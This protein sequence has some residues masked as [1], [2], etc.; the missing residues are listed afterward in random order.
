MNT[1]KRATS[2][3]FNNKMTI[4]QLLSCIL[5]MTPILSFAQSPFTEHATLRD[6]I[7][8]GLEQNV[9]MAQEKA[10]L[11]EAKALVDKM[12]AYKT[13]KVS[14]HGR[15]TLATGGRTMDLPLGD[16][17]NPVY[18]ELGFAQRLDNE[19]I[20]LLPTRDQ[21]T[22]VRIAQPLLNRRIW[23]TEEVHTSLGEQQEKRMNLTAVEIAAAI[24]KSYYGWIKALNAMQIAEQSITESQEHLRVARKLVSQGVATSDML[25]GAEAQLFQAEQQLVEY[26]Y[27][28][29]SVQSTLNQLLN[30][31]LDDSIS[32]VPIDTL[33]EKSSIVINSLLIE[34][35]SLLLL[36][37][38]GRRSAKLHTKLE[39]TAYLPTVN[40]FLDLGITGDRYSFDKKYRFAMGGVSLEWEIIHGAKKR[41]S[42]DASRAVEKRIAKEEEAVRIE[43][44]RKIN[45]AGNIIQTKE[46]ALVV[47]KK[48]LQA[49]KEQYRLVIK[50]FNS[51]LV[52]FAEL[53][54]AKSRH[55]EASLNITIVKTD[56]LSARAELIN[57][58]GITGI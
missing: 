14:L 40:A 32:Y 22:K 56:L 13:P 49:A 34:N 47:A 42:I 33:L 27:R 57:S 15:Y 25:Y 17:L 18:T 6:Y 55:I 50:K 35:H 26:T 1:Q 8:L 7:K 24:R 43:I 52:T 9:M 23:I 16:M 51:G 28:A 20:S 12:Y 29:I 5:V 39:K 21:E 54:D 48:Q 37:Y 30:R 44:K 3:F 46:K 2:L 38:E 31:A 45:D 41:A 4:S 10:R 11:D 53:T 36:L 58:F 19:E